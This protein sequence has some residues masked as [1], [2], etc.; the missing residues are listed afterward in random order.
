M[1]LLCYF[2]LLLSESIRKCLFCATEFLFWVES[3][4]TLIETIYILLLPND[5]VLMT[6]NSFVFYLNDRK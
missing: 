6:S 4:A 2:K 1:N 3:R 5:Y